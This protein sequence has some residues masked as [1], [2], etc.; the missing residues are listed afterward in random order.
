MSQRSLRGA[1]ETGRI[2]NFNRSI[3]ELIDGG[4]IIVGSPSTVAEKIH[5]LKERLGFGQIGV[6]LPVG[7]V[8][9]QQTRESTDAF[10]KEVIP[11]FRAK[12][13]EPA[14]A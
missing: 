3:E 6:N 9:Q 1:L 11:M 13:A 5:D 7:T 10:A 2:L 12:Q 4:Y 14:A 8:S